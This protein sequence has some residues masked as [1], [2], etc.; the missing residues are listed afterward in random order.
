MKVFLLGKSDVCVVKYGQRQIV[1]RILMM[2]IFADQ[3]VQQ[4]PL[5][6]ASNAQ[7][8]FSVLKFLII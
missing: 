3:H 6:R 2:Q 4:S 7:W 8:R 1:L 5:Q